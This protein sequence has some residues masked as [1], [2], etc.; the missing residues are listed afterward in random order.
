MEVRLVRRFLVEKSWQSD[1]LMV[2]IPDLTHVVEEFS[3]VLPK[4]AGLTLL[5]SLMA[6]FASLYGLDEKSYSKFVASNFVGFQLDHS[7]KKT[8]EYFRECLSRSVPNWP[9]F[10]FAHELPKMSK[11]FNNEIF[12]TIDQY[13][14]NNEIPGVTYKDYRN[15]SQE[16]FEKS[17]KDKG[18]NVSEVLSA[19]PPPAPLS[20]KIL[21]IQ[22]Q[23][24][25]IEKEESIE[26]LIEKEENIE[27]KVAA[28]VRE[29]NKKVFKKN[30][31]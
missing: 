3:R 17:L 26:N 27:I 13:F 11:E 8:E 20:D 21:Q 22:G 7:I 14:I 4:F 18:L 2:P 6:K 30:R 19:L 12:Y 31:K 25:T 1:G 16:K 24:D 28:M 29:A 23:L 9:T 10:Y 15:H 5:Q